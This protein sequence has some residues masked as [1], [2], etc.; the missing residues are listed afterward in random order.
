MTKVQVLIIGGGAA[1]R[2][3]AKL[4][5]NNKQNVILCDENAHFGGWLLSDTDIRIDGQTGPQW[6]TNMVAELAA[7]DNVR[8][9]NRTTG[10]GYFQQNMVVL[11][12]RVT[13]HLSRPEHG[14]ARERMAHE[15]SERS[16]LVLFVIDGD[17][18]AVIADNRFAVL[19]STTGFSP[20]A[21]PWG[22]PIRG[23][24]RPWCA[25]MCE[26]WATPISSSQLSSQPLRI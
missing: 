25:R 22:W 4:A 19:N 8:L 11:S 2:M 24:R 16:D 10:I 14:E 1:G 12:E 18:G 3:A 15:V 23:P 13:E 20:I 17:I 5:A 7:M 6:T 9:L 21:Y 26:I